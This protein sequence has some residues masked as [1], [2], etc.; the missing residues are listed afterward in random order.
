MNRARD[1]RILIVED[2][3]ILAIALQDMLESL[4]Y[5]VVGP[6]F[7]V[8]PAL[9]LAADAAIDGA[10]LDVNIG[11]GDSYGI[12]RRLDDRGI[13]YLFATGYGR[14]GLDPGHEAAFVLQ[15]PYREKEIEA[16]LG[17]LLAEGP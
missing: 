12:A 15:K 8:A 17:R 16:A 14:D 9:A 7:R 5:E 2:E 4:G 6:A 3:P 10:I 11:E 13:P 1:K